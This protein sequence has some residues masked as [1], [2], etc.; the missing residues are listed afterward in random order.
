MVPA[1]SRRGD[2]R[3]G[4]ARQTVSHMEI[5]GVGTESVPASEARRFSHGLKLRVNFAPRVVAHGES[6]YG[7]HEGS[8]P[9]GLSCVLVSLTR[10]RSQMPPGPEAGTG[11]GGR[12]PGGGVG[13]ALGGGWS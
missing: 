6:A 13:V 12:G 1:C 10:L 11:E 5:A 9:S 7:S 2:W 3:R 8:H 4:R